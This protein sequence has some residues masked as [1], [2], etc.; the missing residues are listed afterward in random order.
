MDKE[1]NDVKY[2]FIHIGKCSGSL[3]LINLIKNKINHIHIHHANKEKN[4]TPLDIE[5]LKNK[6][7]DSQLICVLRHPVD[8]WI[9]AFNFKRNR[10][11]SNSGHC[12]YW[13]E[14]KSGFTKYKTANQLAEEIY[15]EDGNI[16]EHAYNFALNG[17]DHMK[18]GIYHYLQ[19]IKE[20]DNI[21]ILKHENIKIDYEKY[22]YNNM[23]IPTEQCQPNPKRFDKISQKAYENLKK[24]L[25]KDFET[26][27]KLASYRFIDEKYKNL[28]HEI[29][30]ST[31][32]TND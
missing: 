24:I 9:S 23:H 5:L 30:I 29:P 1:D 17:S 3:V 27:D 12:K 26:I 18:F 8:R 28:C 15:D 11:L 20:N 25:E 6:Y 21:I 19:N 4:T 14:E 7:P 32:I 13:K 16:N 22:I 10:C 31:T 2:I